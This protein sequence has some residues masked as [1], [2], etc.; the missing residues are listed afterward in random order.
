MAIKKVAPKKRTP[1]KRKTVPTG[2][3]LAGTDDFA[4]GCPGETGELNP[5]R[6]QKGCRGEACKVANRDY[7]RAW[8]AAKVAAPKKRKP[9]KKVSPKVPAKKRVAATKRTVKRTTKKR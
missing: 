7:Y 6:Y 1:R 2:C 5:Y 4:K 3:V 8:R 9:A